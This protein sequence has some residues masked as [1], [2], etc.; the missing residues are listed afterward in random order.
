MRRF[1]KRVAKPLDGGACWLWTGGTNQRG[2]GKL[3]VLD[4][5]LTAHRASYELAF[6]EIPYGMLVCHHCDNRLCVRPDHLFLGTHADNQQDKHAKGRAVFC[7]GEKHPMAKLSE[8]Q[9]HE[10]RQAIAAGE[11]QRKIATRYGVTQ[12]VVSNIH[13]GKSWR[14][15]SSQADPLF[16]PIRVAPEGGDE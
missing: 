5:T 12:M 4:R 10:I 1:W 16:T 9:V 13:T 3:R 15:V 7:H 11:G 6:G 8:A 14:R 2:Y